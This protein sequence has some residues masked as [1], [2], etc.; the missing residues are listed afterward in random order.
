MKQSKAC[1]YIQLFVA[2]S[3]FSG[4]I[5]AD[6]SN[7]L[8][9]LTGAYRAI[10][11]EVGEDPKR[12]GLLETPARAAKALQFLTQGYDQNLTEIVNGAMFTAESDEMVLVKDIELYSLCE[13]HLLPFTGRC[14]IAYF[15]NGKVLGLS[16]FARIVDMYAQRLQVQEALTT[17]IANAV[18]ECTGALGVAV[19]VEAKHM[20]MMMR[21]VGKQHSSMTT[22]VMLGQ[23]R[24]SNASRNEFLQLI[25]NR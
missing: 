20:C 22:S 5:A 13:H 19:V 17:Q 15:P 10:L 16:K 6:S 9:A 14:H 23:F 21:G 18:R 3:V 24:E 11:T 1:F 25:H 7:S 8:N 4:F 12:E 2:L